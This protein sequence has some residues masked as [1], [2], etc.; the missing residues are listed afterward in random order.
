MR[1]RGTMRMYGRLCVCIRIS[2]RVISY[3][4]VGATKIV[5]LHLLSAL[6]FIPYLSLYFCFQLLGFMYNFISF[7]FQLPSSFCNTSQL[8]YGHFFFFLLYSAL[9]NPLV[10]LQLFLFFILV[11]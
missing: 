11:L 1:M 2:R 8:A 5:S 9:K 4:G 3:K 10:F 7:L 6:L